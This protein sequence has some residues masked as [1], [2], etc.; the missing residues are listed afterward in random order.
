MHGP[1]VRAFRRRLFRLLNKCVLVSLIDSRT[2]DCKQTSL[3]VSS[4]PPIRRSGVVIG[5]THAPRV[6]QEHWVGYA[7]YVSGQR[8]QLGDSTGAI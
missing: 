5:R 4:E 3:E 1:A 8:D 2:Y 7:G 6:R